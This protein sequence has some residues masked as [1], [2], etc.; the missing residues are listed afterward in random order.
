MKKITLS[1]EPDV[2]EQ[3]HELAAQTGTSVS[4]L[5][6]R[7]IRLLA[8]QRGSARPLGPLARKASGLITLPK[9]RSERQILEDSLLE[10]HG[11]Q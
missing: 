2:I 5:F 11:L 8:Q 10:K 4:S 6:S 9:G 7:M 3:A 1:A